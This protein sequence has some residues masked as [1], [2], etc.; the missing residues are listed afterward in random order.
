[1]S[2]LILLEN[3]RTGSW[4]L[5]GFTLLTMR[6]IVDLGQWI[7]IHHPRG[8]PNWRYV[9]PYTAFADFSHALTVGKINRAF[10]GT[11]GQTADGRALS[12]PGPLLG[13]CANERSLSE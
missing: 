8:H 12:F 1:M 6:C 5:C 9:E 13:E 3:S 2:P 7:V 11:A 4:V 10:P